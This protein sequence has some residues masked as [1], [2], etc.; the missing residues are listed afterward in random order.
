MTKGTLLALALVCGATTPP[1]AA[2]TP[3]GEKGKQTLHLSSAYFPNGSPAGGRTVT[4]SVELDGQGGGTGWIAFDPNMVWPG[5]HGLD[6]QTL[7]GFEH[8]KVTLVLVADKDQAAKGRRLYEVRGETAGRLFLVVP[9]QAKGP[10][11]L[12]LAGKAGAPDILEMLGR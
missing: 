4:L 2:G 1:V 10:C 9:A 8:K 7:I 6:I 11:W 12:L 3:A 5:Q